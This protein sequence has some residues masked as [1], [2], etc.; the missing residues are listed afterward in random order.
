M[1]MRKLAKFH[2]PDSRLPPRWTYLFPS[3][4]DTNA[5]A[6]IFQDSEDCAE[7]DGAEHDPEREHENPEGCLEGISGRRRV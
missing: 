6:S 4:E 2:M 7:H 5:H 3:K 1:D